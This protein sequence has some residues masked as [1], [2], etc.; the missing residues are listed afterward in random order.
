MEKSVIRMSYKVAADV[1]GRLK[2]VVVQYIFVIVNV[3]HIILD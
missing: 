2:S 3:K 1:G